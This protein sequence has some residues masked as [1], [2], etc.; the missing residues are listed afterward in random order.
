MKVS[1]AIGLTN[2]SASHFYFTKDEI[3]YNQYLKQRKI[4]II[5]DVF[6][7]IRLFTL[8]LS[9]DDVKFIKSAIFLPS[10]ID[11]KESYLFLGFPSTEII[12]DLITIFK[13]LNIYLPLS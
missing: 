13:R 5:D 4:I 12:D 2:K 8:H 10:L 1:L 11:H 6:Q 7:Q 9:T 3:F